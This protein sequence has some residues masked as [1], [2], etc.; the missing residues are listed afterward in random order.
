M[1]LLKY[2]NYSIKKMEKKTKIKNKKFKNILSSPMLDTSLNTTNKNS[3][4]NIKSKNHL[5]KSMQFSPQTK[6]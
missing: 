5:Y 2:L 6:Y 4:I 1:L 3:N